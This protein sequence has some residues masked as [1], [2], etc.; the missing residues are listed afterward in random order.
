MRKL[1]CLC[2]VFIFIAMPCLLPA[3][4]KGAG[5]Q[6]KSKPS[7]DSSR[8][9]IMDLMPPTDIFFFNYTFQPDNDIHKLDNSSFDL[10]EYRIGFNPMIQL[11]GGLYAG[12]G[13]NYT[14]YNF[15]FDF[16]GDRDNR[17]L[18]AIDFPISLAWIGEQW[19][20][21]AALL[22][23]IKTDARGFNRHDMQVNASMIVGYLFSSNFMLEAGIALGNDFGDLVP[24]PLIGL[25]WKAVPDLLDM[26]ILIPFYAKINLHPI[27]SMAESFTIS[28]FYELDGDQFRLRYRDSGAVFED[29]AQFTFY[30]I[31]VGFEYAIQRGLVF[32]L[33]LGGTAEGEYEFRGL[34]AKDKGR[35]DSTYFLTVGL[36]LNDFFFESKEK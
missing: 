17:T 34:A 35:I 33:L 7:G 16:D 27:P 21:S 13:V 24:I 10:H 20:V 23:G 19:M 4:E 25:E 26:S 11:D 30:R 32:K 22:P 9:P 29:D 31:G 5:T 18:H 3:E 36:T 6:E 28:L 2:L 15:R 8:S 1:C 14:A 12:V